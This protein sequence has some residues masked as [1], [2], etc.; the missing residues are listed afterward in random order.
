[1][2]L[3]QLIDDLTSLRD[4]EG[5]SGNTEVYSSSDYGDFHHTEQLS[6]I[7]SV[8]QLKPVESAYSHSGLAVARD[9]DEEDEDSKQDEVIVLRYTH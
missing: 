2:T 1:M 7:R 9:G 4:D 3:S 6:E 5:V 8:E